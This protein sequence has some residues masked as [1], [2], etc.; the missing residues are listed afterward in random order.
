[1]LAQGVNRR[2]GLIA[3]S[4]ECENGSDSAARQ[5]FAG[6]DS[7]ERVRPA[8]AEEG[9][10]FLKADRRK[11]PANHLAAHVMRTV[12]RVPHFFS[13]LRIEAWQRKSIVTRA[14]HSENRR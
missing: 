14:H 5:S 3:I 1:M 4:I 8:Q 10:G 11:F 2:A 9:V 6:C 13:E 12:A 7:Q